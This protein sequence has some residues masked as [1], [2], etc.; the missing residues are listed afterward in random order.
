MSPSLSD[1]T[2]E[3]IAVLCNSCGPSGWKRHSLKW[4]IAQWLT[5]RL[6]IACQRHDLAYVVGGTEEERN[7]ADRDF[8][9]EIAIIARDGGWLIGWLLEQ[10]QPV[11]YWIVDHEGGEHWHPTRRTLAEVIALADKRIRDGA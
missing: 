1:F 11:L 5:P 2:P 8:R 7:Q 3:Q 4:R 6:R 9:E 10:E